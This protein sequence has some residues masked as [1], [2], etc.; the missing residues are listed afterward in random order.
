MNIA[1]YTFQSPSSSPVQ[2]GR[3]DPS[4]SKEAKSGS[5]SS[6]FSANQTLGNAQSFQASQEKEVTP[7]VIESR[8]LDTYA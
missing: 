2:V 3:L 5:T 7:S 6:S 4:S 1:K 8:L